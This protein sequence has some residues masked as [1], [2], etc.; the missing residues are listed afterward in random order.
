MELFGWVK[1]A[2]RSTCSCGSIVS[3]VSILGD[4]TQDIAETE[5][6]NEQHLAAAEIVSCSP[7]HEASLHRE[8]R[9]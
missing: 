2:V 1:H 9:V 3:I 5:G 4:K 6:S 7:S 8:R